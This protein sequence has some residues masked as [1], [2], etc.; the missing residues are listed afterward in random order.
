MARSAPV[1]AID[2]DHARGC[3]FIRLVKEERRA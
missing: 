2:V 1:D 3:H